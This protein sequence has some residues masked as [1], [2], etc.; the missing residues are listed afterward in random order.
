MFSWYRLLLFSL[1][2]S[3]FCDE[4]AHVV[5]GG[6]S[7][8]FLITNV[9]LFCIWECIKILLWNLHY[10]CYTRIEITHIIVSW[11]RW[12]ILRRLFGIIYITFKKLLYLIKLVSWDAHWTVHDLI[13]RQIN[14][15]VRGWLFQALWYKFSSWN[16]LYWCP[17]WHIAHVWIPIGPNEL[18]PAQCQPVQCEVVQLHMLT[19]FFSLVAYI[20]TWWIFD[21]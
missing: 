3:S 16:L 12:S 8:M 5:W 10:R 15:N 11:N 19:W 9:P 13:T 20:S 6:Q 14:G 21:W 17:K 1:F 2:V 4:T 18:R 7:A